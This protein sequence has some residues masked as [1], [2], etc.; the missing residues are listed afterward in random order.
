MA[1]Q[2]GNTGIWIGSRS[3]G[4]DEHSV[5]NT[6]H[7]IS[8]V[9]N[10]ARDVKT[11]FDAGKSDKYVYGKCDLDDKDDIRPVLPFAFKFIS[12]A[13]GQRKHVLV[14]C[15]MGINRSCSIV[16]AYLV[17]VLNLKMETALHLVKSARKI[18]QPGKWFIDQINHEKT[19]Y[20]S[21]SV[22]MNG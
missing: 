9:L 18:A 12:E 22:C 2:V 13:L 14:H 16:V 20:P 1:N 21:V 3:D 6:C 17:L 19:K 15:R 8:H 5:F 4:L 7:Q 11:T 10:V